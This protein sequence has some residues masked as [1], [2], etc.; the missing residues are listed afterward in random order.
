MFYPIKCIVGFNSLGE[1]FIAKT[2]IHQRKMGYL[3]ILVMIIMTT[4]LTLIMMMIATANCLKCI[5][6]DEFNTLI[7]ILSC[8]IPVYRVLYFVNVFTYL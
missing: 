8:D 6:N 3:N 4:P 2:L 7:L 1:S 5:S